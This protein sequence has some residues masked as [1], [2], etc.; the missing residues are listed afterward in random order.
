[1]VLFMKFHQL[2]SFVAIYEE[3]SFSRAAER[4]N[5]TQ[6][7][8]SMHIQNLEAGLGVKLFE[9]SAKGVTATVAGERLYGRAVEL[10]RGMQEA[11]EEALGASGKV[12]GHIRVGLLPAFTQSI[13]APALIDF[14]ERY[15]NVHVAILE[16]FSPV[17]ADAVTRGA[18]DF[19]IVP[20][21]THQQGLRYRH[22]AS[23]REI[24]VSNVHSSL[25]HLQSVAPADLPPLKLVLP[26]HGNARR[27]RLDLVFSGHGVNVASVL[28][29]DSMAATLELVANSD[30]MTVLPAI[31]CGR[32]LSSGARKLHPI[33]DPPITVEYG[34]IQQKSAATST[35]ASL[36]QDTLKNHFI[37]IANKWS[38]YVPSF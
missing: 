15:P 1:M 8:L 18:I 27:D 36:F 21:D 37:R 5:A 11:E 16:G 29:M 34:L 19:A 12:S 7:G 22:F 13:L 28:E 32:D 2:R 25:A 3:G 35:A 9:R 14:N 6:S 10:M 17:L 33:M 26:S 4:A 30:F 20:M 31:L 24:L 38:E 23:D